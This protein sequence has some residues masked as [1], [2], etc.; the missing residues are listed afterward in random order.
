LVGALERPEERWTGLPLLAP[1]ERNQLLAWSGASR[2][3]ATSGALLHERFLRRAAVEPR[4]EALVCGTDRWTYGRLERRS[5]ALAERPGALG[6]GAEERVAV[7][8][9]RGADLVAA[10]LG[11][12]RAGAAYVPVDPAYPAERV[13]W[14]VEDARARVVVSERRWS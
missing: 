12:L 3:L 7:C 1:A 6:V 4:R 8:L 9:S 10:L 13:R 14:M 2:R 11:V 5:A